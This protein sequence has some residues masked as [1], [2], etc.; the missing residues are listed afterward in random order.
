MFVWS[1][2]GRGLYDGAV[3]DPTPATSGGPGDPTT[4]FDRVGGVA[5]FET[6]AERFYTGVAAD[7]L[8]APMYPAD[9]AGAQHRLALFLAQYW[10][11]PTTY[12]DERGHPRLR[13][14]HARFVVDEAAKQAWLSHMTAAVTVADVD[15]AD[16]LL[17]T[18]Y[19]TMAAEHLINS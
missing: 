7:P 9:L 15:P 4:L 8:L 5:F 17:F 18:N 6:M 16:E 11:G 2:I 1:H 3:I 10:G 14:R 12:N 13:M 19:F